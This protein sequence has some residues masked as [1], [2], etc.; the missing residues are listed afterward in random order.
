MSIIYTLIKQMINKI[1][2]LTKNEFIE[3]FGNVF[4]NAS[5]IAEKLYTHKPFKNFD[6][7]SEKIL[8]IF[9]NTD[10]EKKLEILN[11][12][13]DLADKTKIGLLTIDSN[14]E[15]NT[16]GLDKCSE[17][18]FNEFKNLNLRYKAKFGFPF[19]YAV[20]GKSKNE[21][22]N[23]FKERV[24]YDINVEFIEAIKQVKKIASLRINEI[25]KND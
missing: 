8:N 16:A 5:W 1:H 11:A 19:I 4:E 13:P 10:K 15:Q 14:K 23:N 21:I 18:E 6:D 9:E 22:L 20:K 2:N 17:K 25:N 7:L 24:A 12:H 3:V